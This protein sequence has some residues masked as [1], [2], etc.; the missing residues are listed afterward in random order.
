VVEE[1]SGGVGDRGDGIVKCLGVVA[2][3][4]A[5]SADLP[6]VLERGGPDVGVGHILRIG[7]AKCLDAAAHSGDVTPAATGARTQITLAGRWMRI[8]V[9]TSIAMGYHVPAEGSTRLGAIEEGEHL[10]DQQVRCCIDGVVPNTRQLHD[11]AVGE[12]CGQFT[13]DLMRPG[14]AVCSDNE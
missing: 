11:C 6:H 5:E 14:R 12:C 8:S 1:S 2:S 10:R 13:D 7:L 9:L 4:S 3:G